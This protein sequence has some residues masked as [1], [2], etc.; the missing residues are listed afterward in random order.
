MDATTGP[1]H[2]HKLQLWEPGVESEEEEEEEEEEI[3]EPL[4]L[5]LRR[6][7]NTPRCHILGSLLQ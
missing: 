1:V 2:Y 7:Q 5:S 3:A 4:V 6:L